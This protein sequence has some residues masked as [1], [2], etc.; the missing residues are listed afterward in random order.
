MA[1]CSTG[2]A[3]TARR[4]RDADA[5]DVVAVR[6][7]QHLRDAVHRPERFD[8]GAHLG[9]EAIVLVLGWHRRGRVKALR[10]SLIVRTHLIIYL[11]ST[12]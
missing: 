4:V 3:A 10:N 8:P 6:E 9:A 1:G 11:Y 7:G 2:L 12:E 5:L